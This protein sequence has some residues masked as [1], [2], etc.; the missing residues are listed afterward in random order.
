MPISFIFANIALLY[1]FKMMQWYL[2]RNH[3]PPFVYMNL[4]FLLLGI[5]FC[6]MSHASIV[7]QNITFKYLTP[8][9]GLS[10][11]SVNDIYIDE[12]GSVWIGT[13]DGLN[14]YN[15]NQVTVYRV[16]KD[17]PASLY[18][19][20][21]LRIVGD[22]CGHIYVLC[23]GG[24]SYFDASQNIFTTIYHGNVEAMAYHDGMLY[25]G[26]DN[27]IYRIDSKTHTPELY[28]E[29]NP[30]VG[31]MSALFFDSQN[32]LWIGTVREGLFCLSE[33]KQLQNLVEDIHVSRMFQDSMGRVWVGSWSDGMYI[34]KGDSCENLKVDTG[35]G[36]MTDF[37]RCFEED[38]SGNI[39]LGTEK[40]LVLFDAEKLKVKSLYTSQSS[41]N[42][43]SH[44]SVWTIKKDNQGSLWIGTYFGG[45]NYFN[46]EFEI[47]SIYKETLNESEGLSSP[48]VGNMVEDSKGRIWICTEGGGLNMFDRATNTFKWYKHERNRNSISH[49]NVKALYLDE[50]ENVIWIGTHMGGLNRLDL[51]NG[52]FT[53]YRNREADTSSIPSDIIRDIL[54]YKD[55]LII[56][57]Q[58]GVC[59]FSKRTGKA[60]QMFKQ[61]EEGSS[62]RMVADIE[63][64]K[65]GKLWMAVTG[66]GVYSYDIKTDDLK[67]Y[68]Y[69][70]SR[71]GLSSNNVYHICCDSKNRMWLSTNGGGL[72][73]FDT[74]TGRFT[75]YDVESK[76]LP[77]N[78]IYKV[79]END[80]KELLLIS[81]K[82]FSRFNLETE[83]VYNYMPENGF[84]LL[85]LNE[86]A[87]LVTRDKEIL[88]GGMSG[89]M[90]FKLSNL[91]REI[92]PYQM[93]W[94][95]L[96]INGTIVS[97]N[98][99]TGVLS[100]VLDDQPHIVLKASQNMFSLSFSTSNYILENKVRME[101]MLE[102]FSD[103]WHQVHGS[104][105]ITYTNL[106]AGY[107]RL[108]V[109]PVG[110]DLPQLSMDITIRP[111]FY[112]SVWAYLIY[113]VLLALFVYYL[114]HTYKARVKLRASLSYEKKHLH[115][116]QE[117]NQS[118]LRFFTSI[119]H[120]FRTP[121][122][123]I[124]G[125]LEALMQI[126]KLQP[127]AYSKLLLAYKS[128]MQLKNLINELLDFRKQ[129]QGMMKLKV[130]EMNIVDFLNET[131]LLFCPYAESKHISLE[132]F[133]HK[134]AIL[135][136]FDCFQMR[137]VVNNL[138]SNA[139][140]YGS[141]G[142][143]VLL[144]VDAD[145][146]NVCFSVTDNGH[147][148]SAK[149]IDKIFE[150]FYQSA[151]NNEFNVG[152]GIGLALTKGLVELH[153]GTITVD[154]TEGKG[155][156]FKVIMP[157]GN[158]HFDSEQIIQ[159][160]QSAAMEMV[161]DNPDSSILTNEDKTVD[162]SVV[163]D[164]NGQMASILIVEDNES[165]RQL[166]SGLF[167]GIYHV[168]TAVDG[169]DAL[170]KIALNPPQIVLSDV[171]MPRMSGVELVKQLK[172]NF[173]TCHIPVVLLTAQ[174]D[175][176]NNIEGLKIGAD[177]YITKPFD[178]RLLVFRCNNLVNSRIVLQ[179]HFTRQPAVAP[180]VLA[181]NQMD[182][183]F[184]DQVIA[185]FEEHLD[186]SDFTIDKLA[187]KMIISRTRLYSKLKAITGQTPN[188]FFMTLRLKKAAYLLKNNMEMNITQI[189]DR[190]GFSSS[191]YFSKLF[192][193]TYQ[194]TPMAYRQGKT[195][196]DTG[197]SDEVHD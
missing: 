7:A 169:V 151:D 37:I 113:F 155:T 189:S 47:Y 81:N 62:I 153:H 98:D 141:S 105:I 53:A 91:D 83:S 154:S 86:N 33:H 32:S 130:S 12:S 124:L 145:N 118:K 64:D 63:F 100:T 72:D 139:I 92:K 56:A 186:D 123:L 75:N 65:T 76:G 187:Q 117:M 121:L 42:G 78:T 2:L 111:P 147:G 127:V 80:A 184:L 170:E 41:I 160:P 131:Y 108:H 128:S 193:K 70:K 69:D 51:S 5:F 39:W 196:D 34:F 6:M 110:N 135:V 28:Y 79:V 104:P 192:K 152:S 54:P 107:Y 13:R 190:I 49:D 77:S 137:K 24:I 177:D 114:M 30:A 58:N 55:S 97:P 179:E 66:A 181:T 9:D 94:E 43:L 52:R 182:K 194:V 172:S 88:L 38:D 17:N 129:E 14:Y 178:S 173:D 119:S 40:G 116:I 188:D 133:K 18:S 50:S 142:G 140:K 191:R 67:R 197:E 26:L 36:L 74:T 90:I 45:V 46:P 165:I 185:V 115:D 183:D 25:A 138:L 109:R 3:C 158:A 120:E 150:R 21:V 122:T 60:R 168:A 61:T 31:E 103:D 20:T 85:A 16:E 195:K 84:P 159:G 93:H 176:E 15:G 112:K 11:M 101:Y 87:L 19:N 102:G 82:G 35:V 163:L 132:F 4:R 106:S 166:L 22:G 96:I 59:M 125:Q 171:F 57:T 48:I 157:L 146:N 164:S 29:F 99:E 149:D 174:T 156:T 161:L 126:S 44:S 175:V 144:E 10:Q 1:Y 8:E 136:W 73:C 167:C 23:L 71:S 143:R 134:E 162:S 89:M 68:S 95:H 27:K 148:I 180:P